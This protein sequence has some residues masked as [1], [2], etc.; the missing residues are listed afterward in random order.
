MWAPRVARAPRVLHQ[1]HP[2]LVHATIRDNLAQPGT[3]W[4]QRRAS[5]PRL[6]PLE[7]ARSRASPR[8]ARCQKRTPE[9]VGF[10]WEKKKK[11]GFPKH[12]PASHK[13]LQTPT[14][15]RTR[16]PRGKAAAFPCP[17]AGC[18]GMPGFLPQ[19]GVPLASPGPSRSL[20]AHLGLLDLHDGS[21]AVRNAVVDVVDVG[22]QHLD[23]LVQLLQPLLLLGALRLQLRPLAQQ[24]LLQQRQLLAFLGEKRGSLALLARPAPPP[25][26]PN[27]PP[28]P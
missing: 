22:P 23:L 1:H 7:G 21:L 5:K 13:C 15:T 10:L 17:G 3:G 14:E 28:S 27:P 8:S 24:R 26:S 12:F 6:Q 19:P 25:Q 9:P 11:A 18:S 2:V 16:Q 4:A 20:R